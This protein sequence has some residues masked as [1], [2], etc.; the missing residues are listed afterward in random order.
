MSSTFSGLQFVRPLFDPDQNTIAKITF[1]ITQPYTQITDEESAFKHRSLKTYRFFNDETGIITDLTWQYNITE[2]LS[3][4]R[5]DFG[6][7]QLSGRPPKQQ[8]WGEAFTIW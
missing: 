2:M 1:A 6:G 3:K 7:W 8:L 5:H 4:W